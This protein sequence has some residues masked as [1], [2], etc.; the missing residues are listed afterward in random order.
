MRKFILASLAAVALVVPQA[1]FAADAPVLVSTAVLPDVALKLASNSA[2]ADS[3]ANDQS[4]LLGGL[5]SDLYHIPG[6]PAD[7]FYAITD[8]GP[9]NDTVQPD[10]SSGTGFVVP[11]FSPLILKVQISGSEVKILETIAIKTKSGVGATGLPNIKGYDA[12]P[13]DVKGITADTLYNLSGLDA[14]GIVKTANGDFW[15][16]DEYAPSL[17]QLSSTGAIKARYVPAGWKG[18]PTSFKAVKSIPSLYLTRKANRGFEALAL[19]PDGRN[20]FIGLQSPLLNPTR[21]IGDASLAT[22]ILRFDLRSKTFT[23]EFVFGF[24]KVSIVDAKATRTSDL[25]LSALVA[26]DSN[27]LL[28]QERTD[29]SFLLSTITIDDSANILGSKWD[30][31]ATSPSLE[32]YTGVGTNAEVEKL[33]AASNKQVVFNSTS[34][35]TMPG[36]IEGVAVIDANH[37]VVVNDNDFNF[38]YNT[39]SGLVEIGKLKTSFLTIKLPAALP[40]YPEAASAKYGKKCSKA[41]LV[42]G[43]LTCKE[44]YNE[45]RWRN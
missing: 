5:G 25:K 21:A 12:V 13:T 34:I 8:R 11:T 28:V 22:R 4:V 43:E 6:D 40:T 41:G 14:E 44:S 26:L 9:N 36:K 19:S 17:A 3:V 10:K 24:E 30:L 37:I 27:T 29:N 45:L 20:L 35:A 39:T 33:I 7:I 32:S 2:I 23:G 42:A 31:P 18:N 1:V 15:I 16:V 38:A